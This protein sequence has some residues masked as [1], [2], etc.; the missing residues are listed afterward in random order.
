MEIL[1]KNLLHKQKYV[2]IALMSFILLMP[3]L[4]IASIEHNYVATDG[5]NSNDGSETNPYRTIEYALTHISGSIDTL[6]V[7]IGEGTYTRGQES[8]PIRP[9]T[10]I[11]M[12]FIEGSGNRETIL[13][14]SENELFNFRWDNRRFKITNVKLENAILDL[15]EFK[16]VWVSDID[17]DSSPINIYQIDEWGG[18]SGGSSINVSDIYSINSIA[19]SSNGGA[20]RIHDVLDGSVYVNNVEIEDAYAKGSGGGLAIHGCWISDFG[21]YV[22]NVSVLNSS[23][24]QRG[25]GIYLSDIQGNLEV[26]DV[27][28]ESCETNNSDGGGLYFDNLWDADSLVF[29]GFHGEDNISG[30]NGG[31][32]AGKLYDGNNDP[33]LIMRGFTVL[34][35]EAK[36]YGGGVS[37]KNARGDFS[38]RDAVVLDNIAGSTSSSN[39]YGGGISL[40]NVRYPYFE[41]LAV[42]G[43]SVYGNGGGIAIKHAYYECTMK[44]IYV[45][46]NSAYGS[47]AKGNGGGI[48]MTKDSQIDVRY[49]LQNM[50]FAKNEAGSDG[51]GLFLERCDSD[52]VNATFY[53]NSADDEGNSVA[54]KLGWWGPDNKAIFYNSILWGNVDVS[55][56]T[57]SHAILNNTGSYEFHY[58]DVEN[59]GGEIIEG[60]DNINSIP[61]FTD[62]D[63]D[64]YLLIAG[65]PCID[66]GMPFDVAELYSDYSHEP[67]PNGE[68]V[69]MGFWGAITGD[70]GENTPDPGDPPSSQ[71]EI[72]VLR[73]TY[74]MMGSPVVPNGQQTNPFD[75]FGDD[76]LNSMPNFEEQTWRLSRWDNDLWLYLRYEELEKDG[77]EHGNPPDIYPGLGYWFVWNHEFIP[78]DNINIDISQNAL[79]VDRPYDMRLA[80]KPVDK[81]RGIN[82]LANPYP[83]PITWSDVQFSIDSTDW[84][85]PEVSADNG[86]VDQYAYLWNETS[87]EFVPSSGVISVWRGLM[88]ATLTEED[89]WIRWNPNRVP[90]APIQT[91][92][93]E[94]D[95]TLDWT[96]IFSARRTDKLQIDY[97]NFIGIGPESLDGYD[98]LDALQL[99]SL[100]KESI[101]FRT[102]L[103]DDAGVLGD[104]LTFD[105]RNSEYG[106]DN[107]ITWLAEIYFYHDPSHDQLPA[108]PIDVNVSWPTSSGLPDDV[109]MAIYTKTASNIFNPD[110]CE[111]IVG[112]LKTTTSRIFAVDQPQN[113][114]YYYTQF[115]IVA[116]DAGA[117]ETVVDEIPTEYTYGIESYPNP[118]NST[119][120]LRITTERQKSVDLSIFNILGQ[121]V[122]SLNGLEISGQK[123]VP[124]NRLNASGKYFVRIY[125]GTKEIWHPIIK[126]D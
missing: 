33:D 26:R 73:D 7:H 111:I 99:N 101:F 56:Q 45:V 24:K 43:N 109:D 46:G 72:P 77:V 42:K 118:F 50:L 123:I 91:S 2:T 25:G 19:P 15:K 22:N 51:G 68:R 30:G 126:L 59:D 89:I 6:H 80:S 70:G 69:N 94:I 44:S 90:D 36:K 34:N 28:V 1:L 112:D 105:F 82:M 62:V 41:N 110:E 27:R 78:G 18:E 83:F 114:S 88:M 81:T 14:A 74:I 104:R 117:I 16:N 57:T 53:G 79:P 65:S 58:S 97:H 121:E 37:I 87:G 61:L 67:D 48:W 39:N 31:A 12:I 47:N 84:F 9:A 21:V 116:T 106:D 38:F 98:K 107:R 124:V 102:R 96:M 52:I 86:W 55:G 40:Q 5:S 66:T 103:I 20:I 115:W 13:E 113:G 32:L 92:I 10:G 100:S 75:A 4:T 108:Y 119:V 54:A 11:D 76:L 93:D 60:T 122:F 95:E 35:N 120:N 17:C 125:D 63:N 29:S 8:Y 85:S 64:L 3:Q 71:S 49:L 23:S